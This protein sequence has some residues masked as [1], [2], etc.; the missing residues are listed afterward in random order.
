MV[1]GWSGGHKWWLLLR[2]IRVEVVVV[3]V[4]VANVVVDRLIGR[5]SFVLRRRQRLELV[6]V[7]GLEIQVM[8]VVVDR[9]AV[10][11]G[12]SSAEC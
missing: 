2:L 7:V 4:V 10:L 12:R 3:D 9:A 5:W 11:D 1:T 8:V 6:V